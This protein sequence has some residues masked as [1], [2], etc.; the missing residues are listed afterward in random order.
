MRF[1]GSPIAAYAVAV[2][3]S[4][5]DLP[6]E[7]LDDLVAQMVS[8]TADRISFGEEP[9]RRKTREGDYMDMDD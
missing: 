4:E 9:G 7:M 1:G 3:T 5:F 6:P 8:R 2:R